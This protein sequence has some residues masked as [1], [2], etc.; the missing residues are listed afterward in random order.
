MNVETQRVACVSVYTI[1][2]CENAFG[3]LFNEIKWVQYY[4][5]YFCHVVLANWSILV[6]WEN[7]VHHT[8][9]PKVDMS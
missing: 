6:F 7:S 3:Y 4:S 1:L 2:M 9:E 5:Y 8:N